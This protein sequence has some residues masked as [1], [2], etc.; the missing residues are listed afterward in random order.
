MTSVMSD[1][2]RIIFFHI[3]KTGGSTIER[4]MLKQEHYSTL[5]DKIL[6][7]KYT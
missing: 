6:T 7:D 4:M 1:V 5:K 2:Y 3:P